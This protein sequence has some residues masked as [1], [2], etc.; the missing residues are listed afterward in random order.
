MCQALWGWKTGRRTWPRRA[1]VPASPEPGLT[2]RR[3]PHPFRGF[4][5]NGWDGPIRVPHPR[6]A[7]VF[8][9]RVGKIKNL[10]GRQRN[11]AGHIETGCP[12]HSAASCGMGG[13]AQSGCPTLA[14]SLFL[15]LGW[16]W[17]MPPILNTSGVP[18]PF[19]GFMRNG[20]DGP[21]RLPHPRRAP[22][23][24]NAMRNPDSIFPKARNGLQECPPR[25]RA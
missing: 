10:V 8:A 25:L 7:F 17:P 2:Q 15:R 12:I 11:L 19:R 14:A 4:M 24:P 18:H 6:R 21:I 20:W 16:G 23:G 9:A 1:P 13:M 3:V 22:F 5:R